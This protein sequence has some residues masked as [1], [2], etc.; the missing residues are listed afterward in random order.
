MIGKVLSQGIH[1]WNM[2]AL[3]LMVHKLWPRLKFLS[4]DDDGNDNAGAM[5]I[6]LLT[7][8]R[9]AKKES[10]YK[11]LQKQRDD[12]K[13]NCLSFMVTCVS[14]LFIH[15]MD[16]F[17]FSVGHLVRH[18]DIFCRTFI[19]YQGVFEKHYSMPPAATKSKKLFLASRSKSRSQGHWPWCHLKGHH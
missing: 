1:L 10:I 5:T 12:I 2:K 14:L 4:T 17:I 19:K 8:S 15:Q 9:R 3:S 16:I 13:P 18:S 7:S 11:C 6:V